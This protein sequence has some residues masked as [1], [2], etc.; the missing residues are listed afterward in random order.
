MKLH[1]G[2]IFELSPNFWVEFYSIK[3]HFEAILK[4]SPNFFVEFYSIKLHFEGILE[5]SPNFLVEFYSIKLHSNAPDDTI[6]EFFRPDWSPKGP[7]ASRGHRLVEK[8]RL[9]ERSPIEKTRCKKTA[10][11]ATVEYYAFSPRK[12]SSL[13]GHTWV[14]DVKYWNTLRKID[15]AASF[16]VKNSH[17]SIQARVFSGRK[18]II[19]DSGRVSC[20]FASSFFDGAPFV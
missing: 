6:V 7:W 10:Y 19:F 15:K 16:N 13:N 4:L 14:F 20:F 17:V 12:N 1:F 2:V 11:S 5:L 8:T 3:L 9:N 18:S